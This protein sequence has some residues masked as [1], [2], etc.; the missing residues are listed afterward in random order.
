M[1]IPPALFIAQENITHN[2]TGKTVFKFRQF[3]DLKDVQDEFNQADVAFMSP[4]QIGMIPNK[5]VDVAIAIDCLH[6][7]TSRNIESYFDQ[8]N[9][10]ADYFYFKCQTVQWARTSDVLLTATSYPVRRHWA[11][12]VHEDCYVP[13]DYFHAIY[14]M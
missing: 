2:L 9:R 11:K 8:F 1:D 10:I 3:A 7:M 14:R 6:E 13:N 4:E 12:L 5:C